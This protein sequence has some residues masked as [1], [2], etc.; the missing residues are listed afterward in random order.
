[1]G[2]P[3]TVEDP[4]CHEVQGRVVRVLLFVLTLSVAASVC[5]AGLC[6]FCVLRVFLGHGHQCH[7]SSIRF[8]MFEPMPSCRQSIRMHRLK[9]YLNLKSILV[10]G[11]CIF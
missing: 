3:D 5:L 8:F 4:S 6:Y 2:F 10:F 11:T 7:S 9:P 1:M